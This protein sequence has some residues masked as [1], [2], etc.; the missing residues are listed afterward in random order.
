MKRG[1]ETFQ[2]ELC[3]VGPVF[4]GNGYEIQKK[5][6]QFLDQQTIGVVDIEK[7]YLLAQ[8]RN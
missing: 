1:L 2:L 7:L 3:V 4:I 5:E 6:Y 8:K